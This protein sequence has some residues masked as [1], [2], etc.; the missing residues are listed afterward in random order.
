MSRVIF[1]VID[2]LTKHSRRQELRLAKAIA[3]N[4][5]ALVEKLLQKGVN[6]NSSGAKGSEPVIF[7]I[8]DKVYFTL[9]QDPYCD[10]GAYPKGNRQ[11][12]YRLTAKE[13]CLRM[14]LEHGADA[15]VKNSLGQSA[16]DIAIVWCMPKIVK[17]LLLHGADPNARG[18]NK[19]TPLI[20]AAILGIKDAR[21]M[22]DKLTIIKHLI[23]SG[24][25]IDAQD[26]DGKTALM[27]AVGNSRIEIVELLI[28]S[29]ASSTIANNQ[30]NK[31][32]DEIS[33]KVT[34][35]Q[36]TYLHQ[37]LTQPQLNS[38]KF[39]YAQL[40]PEGDRLLDSILSEPHST[41]VA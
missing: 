19:I 18:R 13:S 35:E 33:A 20:K 39:K 8:F 27:C 9:P 41:D 32:G 14:L 25:E 29:G 5:I 1:K 16:L 17:L 15:N 40:I 38:T 34:P 21:P 36:R 24:A 31:A 3:S 22:A 28:S 10:R 7:N 37:L 12:L 30:G 6:P 11:S 4:N 2:Q 23:D 26:A